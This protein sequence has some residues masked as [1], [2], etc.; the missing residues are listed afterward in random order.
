MLLQRS[1]RQLRAPLLFTAFSALCACGSDDGSGSTPTSL[2]LATALASAPDQPSEA[3]VLW[4]VTSGQPDYV[5]VWGRAA[6]ESTFFDLELRGRPPAEALNKYGLGVG[7]VVIVPRASELPSGKLSDSVEPVR[8]NAL[9]ATERYA[10]IYVDH[11]QA[12]DAID[13]LAP[14]LTAAELDAA[15]EHWLFDFP[16]G[17]GCGVGRDPQSDEYFDSFVPVDCGEVEVRLGPLDTF[18]FV[19]WT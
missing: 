6:V 19:N 13:A 9:G 15:Q 14:T 17:Y 4:S 12:R 11:E 5:Y 7:V 16:P 1:A 18:N 3:V 10:L 8:E 2:S